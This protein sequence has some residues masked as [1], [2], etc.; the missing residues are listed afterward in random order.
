MPGKTAWRTHTLSFEIDDG[1]S[2]CWRAQIQTPGQGNGNQKWLQ[3][4]VSF[5]PSVRLA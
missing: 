1:G 3:V 4:I 2:V 5:G